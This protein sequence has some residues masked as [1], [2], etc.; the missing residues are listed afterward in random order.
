MEISI[1]MTED[2]DSPQSGQWKMGLGNGISVL[3]ALGNIKYEVS[4]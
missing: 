1:L 3:F 2:L 4:I